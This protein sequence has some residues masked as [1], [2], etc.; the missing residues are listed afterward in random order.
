MVVATWVWYDLETAERVNM[1]SPT[2]EDIKIAM[3]RVKKLRESLDESSKRSK[4]ICE[5]IKKIRD[6]AYE[7]TLRNIEEMKKPRV[8]TPHEKMNRTLMFLFEG[9][10]MGGKIGFFGL[11][12]VGG[13]IGIP[14]SAL[15]KSSNAKEG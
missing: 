7:G 15:H 5:E 3:E 8:L 4:E 1:T 13:S 12:G 14:S 9:L 2:A 6:E 11:L 10:H